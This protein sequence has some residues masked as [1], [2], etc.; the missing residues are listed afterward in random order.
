VLRVQLLER[1]ELEVTEAYTWYEAQKPELSK[2][3]LD[4]MDYYATEPIAQEAP[5]PPKKKR[6]W[7]F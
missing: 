1:A 4:V 3:F 7:Q 5:M 6:W 2:R